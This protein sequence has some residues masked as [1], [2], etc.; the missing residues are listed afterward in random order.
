MAFKKEYREAL[1]SATVKIVREKVPVVDIGKDG[2]FTTFNFLRKDLALLF[3]ELGFK[4]GAEIGVAQGFFSEILCSSIKNLELLCVDPWKRYAG[5]PRGRVD[6]IQ[7]KCFQ[8]AKNRLASYNV[9]FYR[10]YSMDAV[11]SIPEYSL[12]FIYVDG[13]HCFDYVMEDLIEWGKRVRPG[14]II[15]GDDYYEF[16]WAGVIEAVQ[17]YVKAHR[18]K[19]WYLTTDLS[20]SEKKSG[21]P[22]PSFFWVKE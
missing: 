2:A 19:E 16:K 10:E 17:A 13:N 6:D 4:R 3:N 22:E 7:E 14:G 11:R 15:A 12:D 20:K 9:K 8:D 21:Q 5:N 1:H 18:V